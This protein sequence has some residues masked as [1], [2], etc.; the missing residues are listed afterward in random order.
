MS[1]TDQSIAGVTHTYSRK[2]K[3]VNT[4]DGPGAASVGGDTGSEVD[5]LVIRKLRNEG[6]GLLVC[7]CPVTGTNP[8]GYPRVSTHNER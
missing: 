5:L 7:R 3:P 8:L 4:L 1:A 2:S 6:L